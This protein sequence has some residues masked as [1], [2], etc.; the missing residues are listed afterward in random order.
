MSAGV[1]ARGPWDPDQVRRRAGVPEPFEPAPPRRPRPPTSR[2]TRSADAARRATTGWRR[3]WSSFEADRDRLTLELQPARWALRLLA[4]RCR[5]QPVGA[6]HGARR[7]WPLAGGT[8]RR[9]ARV[10]GRALG[11]R[12]RRLGRGRR[13]PGRHARS[14]S[15]SRNGRWRPS[16][17][18]RGAGRC[19]PSELVLLVGQAWLRRRR[20]RHPRRRARRVRVVAGATRRAGRPRPTSRCAGSPNCC[21]P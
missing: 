20:H 17:C 16:G 7:R 18:G 3:G 8:P 14:A 12:R 5:E 2:S 13:E 15:C 11:A 10:V 1:L 4:G 9:L 21:R 19:C 6:V